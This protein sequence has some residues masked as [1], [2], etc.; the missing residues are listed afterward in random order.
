MRLHVSLGDTW[1][2][3]G[4]RGRWS[5]S[6]LG[7]RCSLRNAKKSSPKKRPKKSRLA[8][9]WWFYDLRQNRLLFLTRR[10]R[11]WIEVQSNPAIL[12]EK[13]RNISII[14]I[15]ISDP[16]KT[17]SC[18]I[19]Y[20][21]K[22]NPPLASKYCWFFLAQLLRKSTVRRAWCG[23]WDRWS[24]CSL[25]FAS[26]ASLKES[27]LHLFGLSVTLFARIFP[28][29]F[30]L[31]SSFACNFVPWLF[32][33]WSV[34]LS[35][36]KELF[37]RVSTS[38]DYMLQ[39]H[40]PELSDSVKLFLRDGLQQMHL[41]YCVKVHVYRVFLKKVLHNREEKMQEKMKMT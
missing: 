6:S 17:Y 15:V 30:D 11:G 1:R 39:S 4:Q 25:H 8:S 5:R 23:L 21:F 7:R 13:V 24:I 28:L 12:I 32:A 19:F 2:L 37:A 38:F 14:K 18:F 16:W 31:L 34:S 29:L 9:F 20:L 40:Q 22:V 27:T 26:M 10:W 3:R 41:N 33:C 35:S 36:Y